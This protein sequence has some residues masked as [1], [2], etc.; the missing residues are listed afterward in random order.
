MESRWARGFLFLNEISLQGTV[1]TVLTN[2]DLVVAGLEETQESLQ[3]VSDI[4]Q[5]EVNPTEIRSNTQARAINFKLSKDS[6]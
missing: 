5:R 3:T 1:E 2:G 6:C 4:I